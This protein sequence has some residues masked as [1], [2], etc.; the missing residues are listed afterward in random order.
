MPAQCDVRCIRNVVEKRNKIAHLAFLFRG[1]YL[2]NAK[3]Y[4]RAVIVSCES[5][6]GG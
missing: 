2:I 4:L 6:C 5:D 3:K 1:R